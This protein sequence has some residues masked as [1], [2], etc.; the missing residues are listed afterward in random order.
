MHPQ[1]DGTSKWYKW[2]IA[3]ILILLLLAVGYLYLW[4][5][6]PYQQS[7][8]IEETTINNY[9]NGKKVKLDINN[10]SVA[11][12]KSDIENLYQ[13]RGDA[14]LSA[15][16]EPRLKR[17]KKEG[18]IEILYAEPKIFEFGDADEKV[19]RLFV[20]SG[21]RLIIVGYVSETPLSFGHIGG[22]RY[23]G[24]AFSVYEPAQE[25]WGISVPLDI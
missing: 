7:L 16:D 11:D 23:F 5:G 18:A 4:Y 14:I 25:L 8:R 13:N 22:N 12:I 3:V 1:Q 9:M 15:F 20:N 17:F 24:T 10:P 2:K 21:Q 19:Y 6:S